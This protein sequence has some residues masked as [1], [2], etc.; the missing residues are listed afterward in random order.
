MQRVPLSSPQLLNLRHAINLLLA[1]VWFSR[2]VFLSPDRRP[3]DLP[4][5]IANRN[6]GAMLPGAGVP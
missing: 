2:I 6:V 1:S 3:V 4:N 5:G